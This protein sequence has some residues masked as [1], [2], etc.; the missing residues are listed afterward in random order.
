MAKF[1]IEKFWEFCAMVR[2]NTKDRNTLRLT[3]DNLLGSQIY[4]V[5]E[6]A[7]GLEE[8]I[9]EFYVL[10][11]RQVA[12]TT[13][14]L[15]LD[16]YWLGKHRGVTGAFITHDEKT[17]DMFRV[18]F[19]Q[20]AASTKAPMKVSFKINN[21]TQ[22]VTKIG[23]NRILY[24][25]AGTGKNSKLG[26]GTALTFAH[27]TEE[28]EY[29][30][31]EGLA[32]LKAAFATLNPD[33]L[34]IHESTAQG[35]NHFY[36][37]WLSAKASNTKRAI[38]VGWWRNGFYR[39]LKGSKEYQVYWDGKHTP[40]ERKWVREIK[41]I[42]DFDIDDEQMAWWRWNLAEETKDEFLMFQ[43]YPPTEHYAF[44]KSGSL[45]FSGARINEEFKLAIK[46]K[47]DLF[48]F[49]LQ[50]N[51]EDTEL[52]GSSEKM[53]NLKVWA[54]PEPG[55]YYAIGADPAYGSSEW[56]D[57][58]CCQVYRCYSDGMEQVAEFCTADCSPY[59]FAWVICYL[60]GAYLSSPG[61]KVMMN[62]E[63]NGPGQSVWREI[64]NLKRLSI[65]SATEAGKK[66]FSVVSNLESF[67][68]KRAD[69]FGAPTAFHTI[70][71]TKEKER[72]LI[73][74]RDNFERGIIKVNSRDLIDEMRS[75][76][77]DG[78]FIGAPDR[79]KDDRVISSCL[80]TTAW[81]DFLINRLIVA[82]R[83]G[84]TREASQRMGEKAGGW[85]P[86]GMATYLAE[87]MKA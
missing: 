7:K 42:Y 13:I 58:F 26:K 50:D 18:T 77:R 37:S 25:V 72:M 49:V 12:V 73:A 33:R 71:T 47:P 39:K 59:Q 31:E 65:M 63:L 79:Q 10:K 3:K 78:A 34:F 15:V 41:Q 87:R 76:E 4:F 51:F 66:I 16:L 40:D 54:K 80:A 6:I 64:L 27:L 36:D 61:A 81:T 69:S 28:S 70:S 1:N 60:G 46:T 24:Q 20:I 86:P 17:R 5:E 32:S 11:G 23:E 30:D 75:V 83:G 74:F 29:G 55:A 62:L 57:R 56:K 67:M 9:H 22:L 84:L 48:R 19:D 2:V 44:V 45:F 82:Q 85:Q 38:F 52:I 35:Y 14:C 68:Y 8:G 43:N 53:C 21:R